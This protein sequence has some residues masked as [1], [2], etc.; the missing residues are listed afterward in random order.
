MRKQIVN[1]V[2]ALSFAVLLSAAAG[3]AQTHGALKAHIPFA[4]YV[5][6]QRF[7]AGDYTVESVNPRTGQTNLL[8]KRTDGTARKLVIMS[9]KELKE[10]EGQAVLAFNRYGEDYFLS[11]I[12]NPVD[13]FGAELPAGKTERNLARRFGKVQ[14]ET[15]AVK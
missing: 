13:N 8:I 10:R 4:F 3:H 12:R 7:E 5:Q 6:N 2:V 15:V 11:E 1:A 14:R 9:P